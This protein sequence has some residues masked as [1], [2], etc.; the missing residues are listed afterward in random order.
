VL[1]AILV[2]AALYRAGDH[3]YS[4]TKTDGD[5]ILLLDYDSG[6]LS[7]LRRRSEWKRRRCC[8]STSPTTS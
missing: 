1:A 8:A 4:I 5:S 3:L 2:S 6:R 7:R